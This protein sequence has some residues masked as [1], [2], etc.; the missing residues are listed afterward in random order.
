MAKRILTSLFLISSVLALCAQ[1]SH[2]LRL[3]IQ[4][5]KADTDR[6]ALLLQLADYYVLK[7][8]ELKIDLD[9]AFDC[10]NQADQLSNALHDITWQNKTLSSLGTYY[11]EKSDLVHGK[12]CFLKLADYYHKKG[13]KVQ[14]A[15]AWRTLGLNIPRNSDVNI[16]E[17]IKYFENAYKLY[18]K[19]NNPER[20]LDIRKQIADA[21]LNQGKYELAENELKN[22]LKEY[23]EIGY[24]KLHYTYDLL[25]VIGINQ[26]D[27][28]KALYYQ[29]ELIK[30][31]E[32]TADTAQADY[33]YYKIGV[34]YYYLGMGDNCYNYMKKVM[35]IVKRRGNKA[36]PY[37][38]LGVMIAIL[39][40]QKK[41]RE[42]LALL[43]QTVK[44]F[45]V[46]SESQQILL[47]DYFAR[48][49][50]ML[51]QYA[52]TE[53]Y[54]LKMAG[55]IEH[56]FF[57]QREVD[58]VIM[59]NYAAFYGEIVNFYLFRKEFKKAEFYLK[60]V[61]SIPGKSMNPTN[62]ASMN[63]QQFLL[64]S[65]AGNYISA[66]KNFEHYKGIN[67]SIHN[68]NKSRQIAEMDAK[69]KTVQ[70]DKSIQLLNQQKT[71]QTSQL[72]KAGIMQKYTIGLGALLFIIAGLLFKGYRNK[73]RSNTKLQAKQHEI[74][75][76]NHTLQTLISE[77][78]GL[79][80]EQGRLLTE[81]EW[82]L[83]EV[84]HRVKNNLQIVMSLL[85]SQ[86]AYLENKAA[87][88]AIR[89]S[90]NR[91]QAI[92]LIHQK[93]YSGN[94]VASINMRA[95][96]ADLINYLADSFDAGKRRI[97]FE[98]LVEP[99]NLDL[100]QAVPL[101]LILNESVTNAIKYAFGTD[102]GQVIVALQLIKDESLLLTIVDNGKGLPVDFNL[103]T[104][105]SLG[106]EMMKALSKQ[107][108]G[109]FK[110]KNS[111]GVSISIEFPIEKIHSHPQSENI[112]N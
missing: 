53:Q 78:D 95:Y 73:L 30:S 5:S 2:D 11:F 18:Y 71:F 16:A 44:D 62:T 34:T 92:S 87:I 46:V 41:Q 66:I 97:R 101:G 93:L 49:Y 21:H 3:K 20:A 27:Y 10:L 89:E 40:D 67:D 22:I 13:D 63:Y 43:K 26:G 61:R 17:K 107:L 68:A 31:M 103:K 76:Q 72:Q 35:E 6:V 55:L 39:H 84:H 70:K 23:K 7:P 54:F 98:Q 77:K 36:A 48:C 90:Q 79:L 28:Q 111:A 37:D 38:A 99:F 112:Y 59:N 15:W 25:S 83:K 108:G 58:Y 100:V 52:I 109:E 57:A 110:I 32:A 85:N 96:V 64:D 81:K 24:K 14:E 50:L 9:S 42:S 82:L 60:K 47:D 102:G 19:I 65:V 75:I 88:E 1:T 8:G 56:T 74:N 80:K 104:A 69:Y 45:P 12:A 51:G 106:M 29:L 94:N 105:S 86:S 91:V 33:F 4:K